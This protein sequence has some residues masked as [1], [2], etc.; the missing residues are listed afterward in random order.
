[1]AASAV[2]LFD[3]RSEFITLTQAQLDA[4]ASYKVKLDL[5]N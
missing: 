5:F 4:A 3:L 2:E 1:M